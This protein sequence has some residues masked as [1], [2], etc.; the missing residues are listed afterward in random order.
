MNDRRVRVR[1]YASNENAHVL[2][3]GMPTLTPVTRGQLLGS[4]WSGHCLLIDIDTA[5]AESQP[6]VA[7]GH[8]GHTLRTRSRRVSGR[9]VRSRDYR[10]MDRHL[11]TGRRKCATDREPLQ[12]VQRFGAARATLWRWLPVVI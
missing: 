7:R 2:Q 11:A 4:T 10:R 3:L 5:I 1:G 6:S 8:V 9:R 12:R